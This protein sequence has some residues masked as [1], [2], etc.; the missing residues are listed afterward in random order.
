MNTKTLKIVYFVLLGLLGSFYLMDAIGGLMHAKEGVDSLHHLGYPEY[1]MTLFG[2]LKLPGVAA[3]VQNRWNSV[4]E[5]AF[6][7]F[8]FTFLG[9]AFSHFSVGDAVG[10][11]IFPL[12]LLAFHL[13]LY[14]L[15]KKRL[16]QSDKG[17]I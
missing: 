6:A 12:I 16:E 14:F 15:W 5:W 17:W 2:L 7:G 11:G 13:G 3:L 9:A 8:A 1:L 10:M 4:K